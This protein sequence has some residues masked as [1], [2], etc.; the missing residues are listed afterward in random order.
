V[1]SDRGR[2]A[3]IIPSNAERA[4]WRSRGYLPHLD[5]PH[6]VQ[7]IVFRLADS[8]P[9]K[10]RSGL[11]KLPAAERIEAADTALDAGH[12]R[13]DLAIPAVAELVQNALLRFDDERYVLVAWCVMPNHV[14][15][16]IETRQGHHLDRVVHSWKSFTAHAANKLLGRS[17]RFWA[18]EY[19][20]RYMRDDAQ[21]AATRA[22]VEEN[23]VSAG[24]CAKP[25]DW[26]YSSASQL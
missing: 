21:L 26:S 4:G 24:L 13:R 12:G 23:P 7:H 18:P 8:L 19:F 1:T 10:V 5:T 3:R 2:L 17:Q 11:I 20:D 6:L 25:M 15:A 14:H 22:Y 9:T 16:L